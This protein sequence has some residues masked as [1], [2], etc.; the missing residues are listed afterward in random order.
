M[1]LTAN[2]SAIVGRRIL[3][4]ED[5]QEL[6]DEI[7][8]ELNGRGCIISHA[9]TGSAG[10]EK[11]R[12]K[13]FDLLIVD[14]M[15]PEIDGLSIIDHLRRDDSTV[16]IL[17]ISA[18]AEVD[19]RV[20]GLEAGAD[21]YL[22]KPFSLVEMG[23]RVEALLRRPLQARTT[24]LQAGPISLDLIER[25]ARIDGQTVELLPREFQLLEYFMCR[26]NQ[27]VTRD[28]LIDKVWKYKFSPQTNVV[29]VHIGKLRRKIDGKRQNTFIQ[30][31][32]GYG[33]MFDAGA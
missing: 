15:L 28:M 19:E 12:L 21:D 23:A 20:R 10:F 26:P 31:I 24:M 32:R 4:I 2:S 17:V 8:Y 14:R 33:F 3:L 11:V 9:L 18:L 29:D 6:S 13:S 7:C 1:S 16:P 30:S 25:V 22:P 5:D 27:I